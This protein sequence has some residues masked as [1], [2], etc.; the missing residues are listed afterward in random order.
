M[1]SC[2]ADYSAM[3]FEDRRVAECLPYD[4]RI[5]H[6]S[7]FNL[8]LQQPIVTNLPIYQSATAVVSME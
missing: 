1:L 5:R 3:V 2:G 8:H 6:A 7:I 4:S